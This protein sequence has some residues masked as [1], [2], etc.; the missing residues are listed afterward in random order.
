MI[1]KNNIKQ[2][3]IGIVLPAYNEGSVIGEVLDNIPRQVK[4][5]G[6]VFK[7]TVI[8][9]N[10]GSNDNT[11]EEVSKR[12]DVVLINHILNSGAGAATRT[13]LHYARQTGCEYVVTMDS[14]GQHSIK[15]VIEIINIIVKEN[16]DFVIGSRLKSAGG[17]MPLA[18]KVGN[19]GLS[20]ITFLLL[21]VYVSDSQSGLKAL[22]KKSL[23][24]IDF[25]S[26]NYA[27]CSEMIWKAHQAKLRIDE[28][29]IEA[30]YTDYSKSRGQKNLTGAIEIIKQLIKRRLLSFMN[31]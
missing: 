28:H 11:S 24:R 16:I 5:D 6:I 7:I 31:E 2:Q 12:K 30:I 8:V 27:F 1:A 29:P 13:G 21:G 10:D 23:D 25:H 26:N 9:V 22:N 15:D 3:T 4:V 18:K 17:N 20:F 14:D 19:L